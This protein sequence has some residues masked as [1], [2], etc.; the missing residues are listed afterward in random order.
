MIHI[1][2]TSPCGTV[3]ELSIPSGSV[4]VQSDVPVDLPKPVEATVIEEPVQLEPV[5]SEPEA[6]QPEPEPE[7]V[8]ED[9][10]GLGSFAFPCEGNKLYFPKSTLVRDLVA[11]YGEENVRTEFLKARAWLLANPTKMKTPRGCGKF[12]NSW[13]SR[14]N[15]MPRRNLREAAKEAMSQENGSK[16][17]L[18]PQ[19][20]IALTNGW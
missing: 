19:T 10:D 16:G 7:A 5:V 4:S 9:A 2:I 20:P 11:I 17:W 14:Q 12:L 8:L 13:M 15:N 1:K 3:T 18:S 6:T